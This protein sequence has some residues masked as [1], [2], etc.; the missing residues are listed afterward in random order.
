MR[1]KRVYY[2]AFVPVSKDNRLPALREHRL[3]QADWLLRFYGFKADE[4][5]DEAHPVLD[6]SFNPKTVAIKERINPKLQR[7][8]VPLKYRGNL[9]EFE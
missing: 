7:Q 2:S 6:L 4:L 9:T 1:L 8:N 5:L 3:Y